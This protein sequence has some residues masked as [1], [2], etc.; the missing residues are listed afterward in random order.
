MSFATT[1]VQPNRA[2]NA[3]AVVEGRRAS[4]LVKD[5]GNDLLGGPQDP[6]NAL[7]APMARVQPFQGLVRKLGGSPSIVSWEP[8]VLG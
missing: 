4:S 7:T 8:G 3:F 2:E 5:P 6:K 1:S